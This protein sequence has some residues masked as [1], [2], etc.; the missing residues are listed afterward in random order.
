MH[1]QLVSYLQY[2][3]M[4]NHV[5]GKLAQ[6]KQHITTHVQIYKYIYIYIY[7]FKNHKDLEISAEGYSDLETAVM[8]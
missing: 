4:E 6:R 1:V 7:N 5:L 8:A 2:K 3:Y